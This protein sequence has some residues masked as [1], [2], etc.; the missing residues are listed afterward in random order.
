[1]SPGKQQ[2]AVLVVMTLR[3]R[4]VVIAVQ[5]AGASTRDALVCVVG[6]QSTR[7]CE[8]IRAGWIGVCYEWPYP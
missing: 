5:H 3:N 8:K 2:P 6:Y 1:V 4:P 7:S